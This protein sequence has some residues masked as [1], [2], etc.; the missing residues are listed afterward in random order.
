MTCALRT[1]TG[2]AWPAWL[3]AAGPGAARAG[4]AAARPQP[5]TGDGELRQR[6]HRGRDARL[7]RD[8][9]PPDRRRPARQGHDH[10]LQRAAAER[11]RGLPELPVG[12]ARPG[13][14]G[15]G[16][17]RPAEGGA[18]GRRQAAGRHGVGRRGGRA[19]ATRSSRRSSRCA[20]EPEQPGGRAAAADQR[21]QHHQRQPGQATRWSSPTTP[22]TC[23]ASPRS[24]PRSTSPPPP[25][26]R[27]SRCSTWWPATWRRW[28]SAWSDGGGRPWRCPGVARGRRRA[29]T[30]LADARSNSLI[31][32]AGNPARLAAVKAVIARLD[33]PAGGGVPGRRH[34]GGAPEERRRR[35][36]GHRA[37]RGLRRRPAGQPAAALRVPASPR[38]RRVASRPHRQRTRRAARAPAPQATAPVAASAQPSTG[39]FIQADPATNSLIITAP[40]PLYRQL[41]AMIDQLDRAARRS[42]SRA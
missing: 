30:V 14:R 1:H 39:G 15:G 9:R 10:R 7:R 4:P 2:A 6:R 12:A 18:R 26:S 25:R 19:R 20:R 33:R 5:R 24:S 16:K 34:V 29:T 37:A 35:Q 21:Q 42:T 23:S 40:E 13:L 22:R 32:R 11:A 31:V 3:L 17:R 41:R 27:S 38:G 28:C 36:A 8:D